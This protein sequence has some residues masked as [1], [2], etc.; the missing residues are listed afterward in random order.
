MRISP[1]NIK[2]A[3]TRNEAVVQSDRAAGGRDNLCLEEIKKIYGIDQ[4]CGSAESFSGF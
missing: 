3:G 1:L 2:L 4:G